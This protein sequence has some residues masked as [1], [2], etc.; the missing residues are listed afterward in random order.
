MRKLALYPKLAASALR[1]N[2]RIYLPY[3]LACAGTVMMFQ[4]LVALGLDESVARLNGGT[5][6]VTTLSLGAVVV[7]IFSAILLFYTNSVIIRH[8]KKEFGLYNILGMEKRHIALVLMWETLYTALISFAAGAAGALVFTKLAQMIIVR[9]LHG[10]TDLRIGF[11]PVSLMV[12]LALFLGIFLLTLLKNL[13]VI[14]RS[15]PVEL[16]HSESMGEREPKSRW[17]LAMLGLILL[18]AG[19]AMSIRTADV[20]NALTNFFIAVILV[21]FGTYFLFTAFSIVFLK[22]LRRNKRYYYRTNHYVTVSGMLYRMKRNAMGLASICI[23]STMVLVTVSTTFCLYAGL[24]DIVNGMHPSDVICKVNYEGTR[25]PENC[26]ASWARIREIVAEQGLKIENEQIYDTVSFTTR[27]EDDGATLD[28]GVREGVKVDELLTIRAFQLDDYERITGTE[29]ELEPGEALAWCESGEPIERLNISDLHLK[30]VPIDGFPILR[31]Q[32]TIETR[33]LA[34]VLPDAEMLAR[35]YEIQKDAYG[36]FAGSLHRDMRFDLSGSADE[37]YECEQAV[38]AFANK[39]SGTNSKY[40]PISTA[41]CREVDYRTDYLPLYASLFFIGMFL[42]F[43]FVMVT[44]TIIYYKQVSEGMDDAGRFEIMR[45]VGMT[46]TEVRSSIR[47]QVL[48]VFFL[49]LLAAAVHTAFAFPMMKWLL[50]AF[51]MSDTMLYARSTLGCFGVFAILYIAVYLF[52]AR[53]YNRIVD[54]A[55]A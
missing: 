52:T 51:G 38:R 54:G 15:R 19:Y 10:S 49:P 9:M 5:D 8:R 14:H 32:D 35:V 20:Y 53:A 28:F 21:I 39:E 44:V 33:E 22:M 3:L 48:T 4:M 2:F 7:A 18:A 37:K 26:E 40:A 34:M 41:S 12:T 36:R 42:G 50:L 46:R 47:S 55:R 23:L 6:I 30:L 31:S 43:L 11:N 29:V 24:D 1:K 45:K 25:Q 17:V 27:I 16:L 13:A